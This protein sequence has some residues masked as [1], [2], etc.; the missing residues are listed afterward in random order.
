M[1]LP[2]QLLTAQVDELRTLL[3]LEVATNTISW[4]YYLTLK[5]IYTL[6]LEYF[7]TFVNDF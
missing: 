6:E 5:I 4:L 1:I 3:A 2:G 7:A